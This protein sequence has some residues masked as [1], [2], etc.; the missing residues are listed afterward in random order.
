MNTPATY[1]KSVPA[2]PSLAPNAV[3]CADAW[4][5][6]QRYTN[7]RIGI[8]RSGGS[9]RTP[10]LLDFRLAHARARDAVW[11]P[12][13][14]REIAEKLGVLGYESLILKTK[15]S[16]KRTYLMNPEMGRR[17]D[18]SSVEL[19]K[20]YAKKWGSRDFVVVISDGLSATAASRHSVAMVSALFKYLPPE[21]WSAYPILVIP[22]ARVKIQD[23]V[24]EILGARHA[25]A[26][27]GER[28]GL[29]SPDSLSAYFTYKARWASVESDRNCISN[30]RPLGLPIDI[31]AQKLAAL[32]EESRVKKIG[33]TLLKDNFSLPAQGILRPQNT[34]PALS[35]GEV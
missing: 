23:A 29:G 18:D 4:A 14:P 10:S 11:S 2:N 12:F 3:G 33:G 25:L 7:A 13:N 20:S 35:V 28:P 26:L 27:V 5:Y 16:E 24:N 30:I 21:N 19:L 15:V 34:S 6:L 17:L 1:D 31:A 22:Y 9:Q 8:G 32:L